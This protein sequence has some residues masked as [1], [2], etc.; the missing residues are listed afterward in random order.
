MTRAFAWA[1]VF[2]AASTPA[3]CV[4][5]ADNL[6]AAESRTSPAFTGRGYEIL[7]TKAFLP[8]DFDQE[9]F[10]NL[11]QAWE[12]PLRS[13]AE[14]AGPEERRRM[15]FSRYGLTPRPDDPAKPQQY[16]VDA[17]G[18]WTMS[19]LACHQGQVAGQA[20]P[21]LPNA[22]FALQT[23]SEDVR[24]TKMKLKKRLVRM[25]LASAVFPLGTTNGST[26]AVMFGVALMSNRD[27]ALNLKPGLPP[28][29]TH[30]DHDA[31][32]WWN[33]KKKTRL[34][35]DGFASKGHRPLMQFMLIPENGPEDFAAWE[36][37]FR[38]VYA[39]LESLEPPAYPHA[40]DE[41]QA[42]LGEVIF[43]NQCAECH[44][45]YGDPE[46]YPNRI[47]PI[48]EVGTDPVRLGALSPKHRAGYGESWFNH[49]GEHR[50][51]ADPGGYVAPP[52]DGIW[53]SAPYFHNGSVPTLWHVL[54]SE[55]RPTVWRRTENGYDRTNVGLEVTTY[56]AVPEGITAGHEQRSYFDTTKFGKSASGHTF[57]DVLDEHEKRAVL[58]YLKTL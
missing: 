53:A 23:L 2:V 35:S 10:D 58:E 57:P 51:I 9:T 36:D 7:T 52:L 48:D 45:S 46:I 47:V 50:T 31:P 4:L 13:Q 54:N 29:M 15:A 28:A 42:L 49:F 20:I 19:C 38:E 40:I 39:W 6:P 37:D 22:H 21:G 44:G 3:V 14:K 27:P 16:V 17:A 11:W 5:A 12:E 30:H 18:N 55:Q 25:D 8:P 26:N 34:Y 41:D 56:D 24:A 43:N 1:V 33:F 32:A